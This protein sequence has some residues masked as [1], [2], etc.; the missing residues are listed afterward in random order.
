MSTTNLAKNR[1]VS[2]P[3]C[4]CCHQT[5]WESLFS[6]GGFD[7][8]FCRGCGLHYVAQLKRA[9]SEAAPAGYVD[10]EIMINAELHLQ[11]EQMRESEFQSYIEQIRRYA[12]PG[13]WLDLGCGAGTLIRLAREQGIAIEGIEL[14]RD[15][16]ELA[17]R[18]SGAKIHHK[19]LDEL[20]FPS[21]SFAAMMAINVFSHLRSPTETLAE[22]RRVLCPGGILLLVTG[23]IGRGVRKHHHYSWCFGEELFFLGENTIERYGQKL[24]FEVV[25][26]TRRWLPD[27]HYSKDWFRLKG[28]S[29]LR[30]LAK[31]AF[32]YTPGALPAL[33]ACVFRIQRDNPIYSSTLVLRKV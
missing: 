3:A 16:L 1:G 26:R 4:D 28:R 11:D 30:N 17:R 21:N 33:R 31:T 7:L 18:H 10:T 13:K 22:M 29:R 25:E 2:A 15:R 8:G 9:E 19:P 23:E 27:L 14:T 32:L 6:D 12:P 5:A 20:Q 24:G